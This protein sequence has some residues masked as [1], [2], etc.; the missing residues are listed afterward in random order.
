MFQPPRNR[1]ASAS[2]RGYVYQVDRTVERWLRLGTGQVLELERGEDIDV[3]GQMVASG[4]TAGGEARLLEQVKQREQSLTLRTDAAIEAM[5]NF[6]DHRRHNPSEDLRFCFLT[7]AVTGCE[8]LNPF[9][10]RIPGILLWEQ[11]RTAQLGGN[12]IP[13]AIGQLRQ[14]LANSVKPDSLPEA[15]WSAWKEFLTSAPAEEFRTFIDRLEWS[16]GQPDAV[17]LP[18]KLRGLLLS[19]GLAGT[20]GEA[21]AL[22]DRLF[23][24]VM[25]LLST[26][27][28][29]RL[30][31]ED[32][33]RVLVAPTLPASDRY[34][35]SQLRQPWPRMPTGSPNLRPMS[36][37]LG[38]EL[39]R[40][41]SRARASGSVLLSLTRISRCPHRSFASA[42][43]A[44]RCRPSVKRSVPSSG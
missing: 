5:A 21:E 40:C 36:R 25:R 31:V 13:V 6:H 30:T 14:F 26:P 41:I 44:R 20:E 12:E 33:G 28:I 29:K 3:V 11:I 39:K 15:V 43:G 27:G 37:P 1:D 35:L 2:I 16:T 4:N 32:R 34:L 10:N 24:H 23:V 22:A 9:T 19:L 7:N 17:V 8:Q 38:A 42:T 18:V